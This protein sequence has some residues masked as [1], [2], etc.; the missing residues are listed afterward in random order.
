MDGNSN[1][2]IKF[3]KLH[4]KSELLCNRTWNRKTKHK[5]HLL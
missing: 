3:A 5:I 1:S 4:K 2:I